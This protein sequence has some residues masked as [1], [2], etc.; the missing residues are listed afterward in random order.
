MSAIATNPWLLFNLKGLLDGGCITPDEFAAEK[1]KLFAFVQT[2]ETPTPALESMFRDLL[3]S[4]RE[5]VD[6]MGGIANGLSQQATVQATAPDSPPLAA[7]SR[8]RS[9]SSTVSHVWREANQ[10]SLFDCGVKAMIPEAATKR[11]RYVL[12]GTGMHK[13]PHC[14]FQCKTVGAL[15]MHAKHKHPTLSRGNQSVGSMFLNLL[16]PEAQAKASV[17]MR[18][19]ECDVDIV[20]IVKDIVQGACEGIKTLKTPEWLPKCVDGRQHNKGATIRKARSFAFKAKVIMEYE[21]YLKQ[22]GTENKP[23]LASIVA[24]IFD[25]SKH[26]VNYY[27]K[28]KAAILLNH[29]CR[30]MKSRSRAKR[31]QSGRFAT[32]EQAVY[33]QFVRHRKEGRQV[34]PKYLR[35]A[36]R[37]EVKKIIDDTGIDDKLRAMAR[38]F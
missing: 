33:D 5:L 16:G 30:K 35:Q 32:A 14:N 4:N 38:A 29:H 2:P 36:M 34:G 19:R 25:V 10:P 18:E 1:A 23:I 21:R 11:R 3:Q 22:V 17:R 24:D 12:A 28:N 8:K 13:C 31:Q 37:R 9:A 15:A 20:F 7:K 6:V 27:L 26:Q